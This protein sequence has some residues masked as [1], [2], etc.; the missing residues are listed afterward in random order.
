MSDLPQTGIAKLIYANKLALVFQKH[1][2]YNVD[3]TLLTN[4]D[5]IET[6]LAK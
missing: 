3:E 6:Y 1:K 4:L 2:W 5:K